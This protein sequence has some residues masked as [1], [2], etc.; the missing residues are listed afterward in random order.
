[1]K[2]EIESKTHNRKSSN[3]INLGTLKPYDLREKEID[4]ERII[5]RPCN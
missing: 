1:M 3:T 2:K 5:D 4:E